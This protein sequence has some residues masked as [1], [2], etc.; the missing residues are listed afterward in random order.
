MKKSKTVRR[1][2]RKKRGEWRDGL[3]LYATVITKGK[4]IGNQWMGRELDYLVS[5]LCC[6]V[7]LA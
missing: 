2:R 3:Y 6:A 7:L 1:K 5:V 4:V